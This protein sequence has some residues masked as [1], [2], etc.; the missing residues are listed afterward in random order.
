MTMQS[1]WNVLAPLDLALD[2]SVPV[3]YALDLAGKINAEL[4]LLHVSDDPWYKRARRLGWL[5][6][7]PVGE[8]KNI[9]VHRLVLAGPVPETITRYADLIDADFIMLTN[10]NPGWWSRLWKS[11]VV[12]QV[13]K[14]TK[15]PVFIT[16]R[17]SQESGS[18]V[19]FRQ[20]LCLLNLD[21]TDD[22]VVMHAQ[23][24]AKRSGGSLI[25][26]GVIPEAS[27]GLLVEFNLSPNRPLSRSVAAARIREIGEALSVPYNSLIL[28]GRTRH[29][30]L[31]AARAWSA[32]IVVVSRGVPGF[33]IPHSLDVRPALRT[34]ACPLL[35]VAWQ[36][37]P[38][39]CEEE[40]MDQAV[41][42]LTGAARP[43]AIGHRRFAPSIS[44]LASGVT[45]KSEVPQDR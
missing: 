43:R 45:F 32:D 39:P 4:T 10:R 16:N 27:E 24:L 9:D 31:A 22:A 30:L 37:P 6:T 15:R 18:P 7:G 8:Q 25:L 14:S 19:N 36:T 17:K 42:V 26:L 35:S 23:R 3:G 2:A 41:S 44:R 13:M 38:P 5:G 29:C 40:A 33:P 34:L 21:G 20:I 28:T 11:S 1:K 12:D